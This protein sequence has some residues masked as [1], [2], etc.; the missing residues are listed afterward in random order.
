M[1]SSRHDRGREY[2]AS[3]FPR[4][5][6]SS[7]SVSAPLREI[8]PRVRTACHPHTAAKLRSATWRARRP[9]AVAFH[10][11]R[12]PLRTP[13]AFT[14]WLEERGHEV[15]R[16]GPLRDGLASITHSQECV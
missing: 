6:E 4:K 15:P 10:G 3:S 2:A 1:A 7:L 16:R 9:G 5:R 8:Q 13:R 12:L 14:F 11:F